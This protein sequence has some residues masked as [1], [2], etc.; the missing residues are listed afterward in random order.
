V[1]QS[2]NGQRPVTIDNLQ[3]WLADFLKAYDRRVTIEEIK[4]RVADHFQLK[5]ADLESPNRSRSIVRPR[6]IAMYLSRILTPRSFPEIGKRFGDRDHTTVMHA[7]TTVKDFIEKDTHFAEEVESLRLSIRN[8]PVEQGVA[9]AKTGP[10]S[11]PI[12]AQI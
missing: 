10:S 9:D 11:P 2:E 12:Q 5:V 4:R 3:V 6:Q 8:W 7:V 1:T